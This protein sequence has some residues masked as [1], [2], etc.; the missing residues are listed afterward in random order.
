MEAPMNKEQVQGKM[1][2]VKAEF[3]KAWATLTD[4]DIMLYEANRDAFLGRLKE[5][6]GLVKNDAEERVAEFEKI[7]GIDHSTN[8]AA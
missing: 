6:Y 5:H 1:D 4:D 3:K 8:K 7:C 2:Q